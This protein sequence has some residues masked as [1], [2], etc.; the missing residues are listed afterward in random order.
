MKEGITMKIKKFLALAMAGVM[1]LCIT[2]CGANG[3]DSEYI[4]EK[5]TLKVGYTIINPLNYEE[6]DLPF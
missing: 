3:S 4:K 6:D 2:G 1:A 5:G